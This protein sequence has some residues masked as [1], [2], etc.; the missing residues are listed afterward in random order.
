MKTKTR[1]QGKSGKKG[2]ASRSAATPWIVE[3]FPDLFGSYFDEL[4]TYVE[5]RKRRNLDGYLRGV[6]AGLA[7]GDPYGTPLARLLNRIFRLAGDQGDVS[8]AA[9]KAWSRLDLGERT[10]LLARLNDDL[11]AESVMNGLSE[12]LYDMFHDYGCPLL[13]DELY[14]ELSDCDIDL[15]EGDEPDPDDVA[16][17]VSE[18]FDAPVEGLEYPE[19]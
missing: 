6:L 7:S 19:D 16:Y 10:E 2:K 9:R 14:V 4:Q 5:G 17:V 3:H 18:F 13:A 11:D 12:W 1:R 15:Y 8:Q